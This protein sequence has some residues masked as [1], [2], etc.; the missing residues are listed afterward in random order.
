M[1]IAERVINRFKNLSFRHKD[2]RVLAIVNHYYGKNTNFKGKS[3]Y[4]DADLRRKIVQRVIKSL[5]KIPNVEIKICGIENHSLVNIDKDFSYIENPAFLVYESIQWMSS[6]LDRYDYFINIE[7]DILFDNKAFQRILKFDQES[8]I[9]ECFHPNRMEF[10]NGV[11]YCVD[12]KA[13]PGWKEISKKYNKYELRVAVNPHSGIS[14]L[15]KN[16]LLFASHNVNFKKRDIIIGHF[17]ASAYANLHSPF[18]LFRTWRVLSAHK[19]IHLDNWE[20]K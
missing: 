19:V 10:K 17:M 2:P 16:K 15:S 20:P 18:L 9:N 7:D 5:Y 1:Q 11:E 13:M 3:T 4:Q 12:L 14:V 6:L 8:P